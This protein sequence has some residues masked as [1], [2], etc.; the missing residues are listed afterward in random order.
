LIALLNDSYEY[1]GIIRLN[2]DDWFAKQLQSKKRC[3]WTV[4]LLLRLIVSPW[5]WPTTHPALSSDGNVIAA[6]RNDYQ[7]Y[8][9]TSD[10][11]IRQIESLLRNFKEQNPVNTLEMDAMLESLGV[12]DLVSGLGD[13]MSETYAGATIRE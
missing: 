9:R 2:E 12:P 4:D 5:R 10:S 8:I 6:S 11:P 7:V 1:D 13:S 3:G